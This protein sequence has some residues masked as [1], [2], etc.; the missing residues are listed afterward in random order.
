[1]VVVIEK[2]GAPAKERY[3]R[4]SETGFEGDVGEARVA[5]VAIKSFVVV[6]KGRDEQAE[7]A[8][9]I[10]VA[11]GDAHGGLGAAFFIKGE[12]AHVADV[13]E[14]AV[15]IGRASCRERV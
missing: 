11:Q 12:A 7:T 5:V 15:E 9:V 13:F 1:V 10:V 6:G 2:A 4:A 14:G 8:G 3:R